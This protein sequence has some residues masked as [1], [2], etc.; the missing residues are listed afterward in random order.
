MQINIRGL[1][2]KIIFIVSLLSSLSI[3]LPVYSQSANLDRLPD[4]EYHFIGPPSPDVPDGISIL[5][6]K[7]DGVTT[8][9][10]IT[11]L[12]ENECFKG[13][14]RGNAIV[15]VTWSTPSYSSAGTSWQFVRTPKPILLSVYTRQ[16]LYE[17]APDKYKNLHREC[18]FRMSRVKNY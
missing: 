10:V 18:L 6:T 14:A 11:F 2:P 1:F 7:K 15:N 9:I 4:G 3:P 17:A 5:L 12:S 8:G 16:N 13:T